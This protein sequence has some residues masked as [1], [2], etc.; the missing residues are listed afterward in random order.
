MESPGSASRSGMIEMDKAERDFQF[1]RDCFC[2][3]LT[4]LGEGEVAR[5]LSPAEGA[6]TSLSTQAGAQ[7]QSIA[8][9][10]LNMVEENTAAAMR[11]MG[12]PARQRP[13]SM[14]GQE[15]AMP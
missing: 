2:E 12:M 8:F 7:A 1:L 13:M 11:S 4:E 10:L 15:K 6:G 3:V 14:G 5:V 9:Q